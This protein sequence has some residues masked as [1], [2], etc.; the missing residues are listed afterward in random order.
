[1]I[2][3]RRYPRLEKNIPLKIK[4]SE[5]DI[6]TETKNISR[7][8]AYCPVD[9]PLAPMTKVEITLLLPLHHKTGTEVKK[10]K[11]EGIVVRTETLKKPG[12]NK[13][14]NVAIFFT[15]LKKSDTAKLAEYVNY[16]LEKERQ[17]A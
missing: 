1:M 2:E 9:H 15:H 6:V 4:D 3:R 17:P 10:I 11:C 5:F 12:R 13:P 14:Y 16:H 8:G 7:S